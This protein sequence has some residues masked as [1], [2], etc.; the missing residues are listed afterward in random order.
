MDIETLEAHAVWARPLTP[1]DVKNLSR[2][3]RRPFL[4]DMRSLIAHMLQR[5]L[6]LEQEAVA[7]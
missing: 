5:G 3:M 7:P 1:A 4:T 2:L 6:K